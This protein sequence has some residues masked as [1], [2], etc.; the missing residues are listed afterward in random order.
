MLPPY[1]P[2]QVLVRC[3]QHPGDLIPHQLHHLLARAYRFQRDCRDRALPNALDEPLRD[4]EAHIRLEQVTPD[5]AQGLGD[6][7]LR[8]HAASRDAL[9]DSGELRSEG[10]KHKPTKLLSDLAESKWGES[11]PYPRD[12]DGRHAA[13]T[14]P[15]RWCVHQPDYR[16]TAHHERLDLRPPARRRPRPR[17]PLRPGPLDRL[18]EPRPG[19]R[20]GPQRV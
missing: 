3:P 8:Q 17:P 18:E 19:A 20:G 9:Q 11:S 4:L 2:H 7:L 5:L 10:R 16:H 1:F 12:P 15:P 14:H 13:P 6:I